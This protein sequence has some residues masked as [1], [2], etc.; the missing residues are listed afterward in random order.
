MNQVYKESCRQRAGVEKAFTA[1]AL[2]GQPMKSLF[3]NPTQQIKWNHNI[4]LC[5]DT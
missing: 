3:I 2:G 4:T 5:K 1:A